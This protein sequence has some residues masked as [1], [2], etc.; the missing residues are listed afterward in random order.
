MA[1]L[2][3]GMA[4]SRGWMSKGELKAEIRLKLYHE[5]IDHLEKAKTLHV[6]GEPQKALEEIH[7]ATKVVS[8][9]PDAYDLARKIYLE[10]GKVKEARDQEMLFQNY[11]GANGVSLYRLRDQLIEDIRVREEFAA[12]PDFRTFPAFLVSAVSIGFLVLVMVFEHARFT[13]KLGRGTNVSTSSL[14]LEPFPDEEEPDLSYS[15]VFKTCLFLLPGPIL[16]ALLVLGGLRHYSDV[17]PILLFGWIPLVLGIYLIF[18]ADLSGLSS[19][20]PRGP[21]P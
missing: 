14:I 21:R 9:F 20:R 3:L 13:G 18:F 7:R 8:A 1:F 4:G 16:F 11:G 12:P 10:W 6:Q 2:S 19:F 5:A 17:I 15:W